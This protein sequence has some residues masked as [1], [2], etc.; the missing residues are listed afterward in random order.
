MGNSARTIAIQQYIE[1]QQSHDHPHLAVTPCGFHISQSHPYLGATPDGGV[2]D[3]SNA[4]KEFGCLKIKC[5]YTHWNITPAEACSTSGFCCSL[6]V[7]SDNT[8]P[9]LLRTNHI[10]YA[11]VPG[12]MGIG[13]KQW[14]DFVVY[15]TTGIHVQRIDFDKVYWERTLLPKLTE[16]YDNWLGPEIVSPVHVLGLPVRNLK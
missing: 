8:P 7:Y 9:L 3:Q 6:E 1:Y 12:Q 2:F 4:Q 5:P 11:Q 13:N 14:C 15:T 16:F 10:D